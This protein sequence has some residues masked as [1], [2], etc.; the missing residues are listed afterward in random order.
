MNKK[1]NFLISVSKDEKKFVRLAHSELPNHYN[2]KIDNSFISLRYSNNITIAKSNDG[3]IIILLS[4]NIYQDDLPAESSIEQYLLDKYLLH[5]KDFV[6]YLNG[7]F[8]IFFAQK[9][10]SDAYFATDRLN[11]R[12]IY[13]FEQGESLLFSTNINFLSLDECKL[14][15][16][17][18]ASYLINGMLLNDLTVFEEIKKLDR[19]SLHKIVDFKII[20]QKYWD[21]NF[22]NEYGNRSEKELAREL[23]QL[24]LKSLKS[25]LRGKE[26]VFISLSGGYDS[27]GI[28]AMIKNISDN[29]ANIGCISHNF[30]DR[31]ENTDS[32]IAQQ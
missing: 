8:C 18:A 17:G 19:A 29:K 13:K 4:G 9:D 16:A 14:S 10:T 22:T 30:G 25:I 24:Y 26:N 28:A 7:S 3:N 5:N 27:R 23:H 21:Y 11:T 1:G 15:Y 20:S 31:M 6:K 32:D 12:K 2:I